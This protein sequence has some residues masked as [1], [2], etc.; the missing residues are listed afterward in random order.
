VNRLSVIIRCFNEERHIGKLLAGIAAQTLKDVEIILVDSG[1][2]DATLAVACQ[3]PVRVVSIPS[4][5]FSFGRSLNRGCEAATGEIL[6]IASAHVYPIYDTWLEALIAPFVDPKVALA[7][8]KQQGNEL[9]KFSEHQILAK[10]FPE[11]S[12]A[13]QRHPFCNNANSAI[14]REVW[15]QV[16][17]DEDLTGLEDLDWAKRI[18]ALGWY[19]AYVAEAPVA[20]VHEERLRQTFNRYRREALAHARIFEEQ[21]FDH[22]DLIRLIAGNVLSD[23]VHSA[24]SGRMLENLVGIPLFRGAQ[25][26]GTYRGFHQHGPMTDDLRQRFY[27]PSGR[28]PAVNKLATRTIGAPIDYAHALAQVPHGERGT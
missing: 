20:H 23:Y 16:R 27:Y 11:E 26:L 22:W 17:F 24:R 1:S 21:R 28:R 9:T 4:E 3:H 25:F 14:R 6:V 10:W 2:T 12:T 13:R 18:M 5:D 7:Y 19:I 8:G 15:E